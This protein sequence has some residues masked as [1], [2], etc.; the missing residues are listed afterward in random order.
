MVKSNN[1]GE[2]IMTKEN[3]GPKIWQGCDYCGGDGVA[4]DYY[5]DDDLSDVEHIQ[6]TY[7]C[8]YCKGS[9]GRWV[10]AYAEGELEEIFPLE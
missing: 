10:E 1:E 7:H 9:G 4:G 8:S 2:I 3:T 6:T 5:T